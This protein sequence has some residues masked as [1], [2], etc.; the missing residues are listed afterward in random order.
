M[1]GR[2]VLRSLLY[3]EG[4]GNF[5]DFSVL[6]TGGLTVGGLMMRGSTMKGVISSGEF[7]FES[8]EGVE[9]CKA[10][11]LMSNASMAQL[12]ASIQLRIIINVL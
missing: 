8:W 6:M 11:T 3:M 7:M 4:S 1:K 2:N 9:C 5:S 10:L 12:K